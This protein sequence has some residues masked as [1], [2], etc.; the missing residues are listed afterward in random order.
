M[1][2]RVGLAAVLLVLLSGCSPDYNWRNVAVADGMVKAIFPDKPKVQERTL[3]FA[4]HKVIF[5]LT[6]ATVDGV[7]FAVGYAPLPE[8][9]RSDEPARNEMGRA[10]IR[11]FY[12]NLGVPVPDDLPAFG[13]RFRI[14][15]H[16]AQGATTLQA[17][18]WMLPHALVEG[19]VTSPT[20][21]FPELQADE[22]FG[23]LAAGQ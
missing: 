2:L 9:L 3:E 21:S 8:A 18:A 20:A 17:T 10:V 12:Q 7:V 15:G 13:T 16:S 6:T 23:Y 1:L 14:D 11:S 22:F 4:G 5:S 19:I